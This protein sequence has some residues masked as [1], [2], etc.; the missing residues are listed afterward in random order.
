[1]EHSRRRFIRHGVYVCATPLIFSPLIGWAKDNVESQQTLGD[2]QWQT[3]RALTGRIIPT[4]SSP[5]ATEA[6]CVAFIDKA[7]AEGNADIA[8]LALDEMH[9]ICL[10]GHKKSFFKLETSLQDAFITDLQKGSITQWQ[11]P[12]ITPDAF[13]NMIW[14]MTITAFLADPKYGGNADYIGWKLAGFPGHNHQLGII[15]PEQMQGKRHVPTVWGGI[16]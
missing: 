1:M 9:R 14:A 12:K 10:S 2:I 13:F 8:S 7:L 11:Q 15:S 5:G 6:N 16:V 4:D 3:L